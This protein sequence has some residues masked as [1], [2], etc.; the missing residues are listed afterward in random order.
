VDR[1]YELEIPSP[2]SVRAYLL[3]SSSPHNFLCR[4][5][6][7]L[8]IP[9]IKAPCTDTVGCFQDVENKPFFIDNMREIYGF[10]DADADGDGES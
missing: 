3:Y 6:E 4:E 10:E 8:A 2:Q 9:S 7:R 5:G 1:G